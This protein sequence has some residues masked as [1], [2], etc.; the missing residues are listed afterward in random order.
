[1]NDA[2][3]PSGVESPVLFVE[4][5]AG[6][7]RRIGF[8][9]LNAPRTLNGLSLDMARLLDAQLH[10]WAADDAIAMVV[11]QGAG[12]KAFCAGGDL[13]S[14]YRSMV[15]HRRSGSHDVRSNAYACNFFSV[16]YRLDYRIHTYPKPVLCWGHGI[17]MGGGIG[18]M[19]GASHRVVTERS[20]LAMPEITVGLYPD[21]GG[22]W[23]LNRVPDRAGLFLALTAAPLNAS[24]AIHGGLADHHL[25]E[26]QR[27]AVYAALCDIDWVDDANDNRQHLTA[28]LTS[29]ALATVP[30]PLQAHR[31]AIAEMCTSCD[32]G[33]VVA[34]IHAFDSDDAWW[35]NARQALAAGSPG[36]ARLAFELQRR[37]ASMS[38]ADVFRLEYVVSLHCAA[39][40]G[41]AEGIRAL[42]IDKDRQ[43][44]WH[45]A[46]L[47]EATHDWAETFFIAP[48]PEGEHPLA[49]LGADIDTRKPL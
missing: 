2:I 24:D 40:G 27:D 41:F 38:L 33:E 22:S 3:A 9:T 4:R 39:H 11:L 26:A 25:P 35:V 10:A 18:L 37:A 19:A 16:E 8:A 49:N 48:W 7:G 12:E 28:L 47:P 20:K 13:H 46:T 23:L 45:P 17:V 21:V 29:H 30:G 43:P 44:H 14:L 31:N 42:L 15:D 6:Q 5:T 36:S 1:M 34:A 32:L